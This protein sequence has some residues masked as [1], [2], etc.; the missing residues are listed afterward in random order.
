MIY[1]D[2]NQWHWIRDVAAY[3]QACDT[4]MLRAGGTT[5]ACSASIRGSLRTDA[6]LI[7]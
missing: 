4:I 6:A 5:L 1:Y 7:I 2:T 3:R